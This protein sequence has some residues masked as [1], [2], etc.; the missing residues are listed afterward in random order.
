MISR[1]I[2]RKPKVILLDEYDSYLDCAKKDIVF[3]LIFSYHEQ[4]KDITIISI[5]HV[6]SSLKFY[7]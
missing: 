5:T 6:D 2:L 4:N 7:D 3:N 1:M